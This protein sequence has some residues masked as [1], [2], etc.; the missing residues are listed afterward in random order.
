MSIMIEPRVQSPSS[1][2][3]SSPATRKLIYVYHDRTQGA[4]SLR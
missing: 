4:T 1:E 2:T 3:R